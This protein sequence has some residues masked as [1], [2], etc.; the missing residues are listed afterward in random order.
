LLEKGADV[1]VKDRTRMTA[2]H[3]AMENGYEAV[4]RTLF[5]KDLKLNLLQTD[6]VVVSISISG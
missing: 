1:A 6:G 2:L 3:W 4:I 5:E